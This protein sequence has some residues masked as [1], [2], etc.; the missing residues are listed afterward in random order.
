MTCW[1]GQSYLQ[2]MYCSSSCTFNA[3]T[4]VGSSQCS[5]CAGSFE[6]TLV[7]FS[8]NSGTRGLGN[9]HDGAY[10]WSMAYQ[11][12][13]EEGNNAGCRNDLRG[14]GSGHLWIK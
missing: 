4:S 13:P 6:G 5:R 14:S 11:R 9:H 12:H 1:E 8:P 10:P 7:Q 3:Q 2:T